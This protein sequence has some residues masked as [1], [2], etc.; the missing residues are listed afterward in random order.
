MSVFDNL[1]KEKQHE[2]S[3]NLLLLVRDNNFIFN[4]RD[5]DYKNTVKIQ[6]KFKEFARKI[7]EATEAPILKGKFCI[8]LTVKFL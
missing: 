2:V 4:K 5:D 1:T 6:K 7:S 8:M 3:E